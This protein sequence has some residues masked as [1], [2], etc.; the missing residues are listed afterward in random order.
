[1]GCVVLVLSLAVALVAGA[2][3]VRVV[4]GRGP[5]AWCRWCKRCR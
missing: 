3:D 2:G 4:V 1:M 5:Y